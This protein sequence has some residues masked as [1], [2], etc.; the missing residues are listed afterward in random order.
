[1]L[2]VY[3]NVFANFYLCMTIIRKLYFELIATD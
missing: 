2:N 3:I 1:M